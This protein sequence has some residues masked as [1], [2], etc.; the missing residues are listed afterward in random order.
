MNEFLDD[1]HPNIQNEMKKILSMQEKSISH[2]E[3]Y[4]KKA[5]KLSKFIS[6]KV[7]KGE[8]D[9]LMNRTDCFRIKKEINEKI[10]NKLGINERYGV[11]KWIVGLRRPDNFRGVRYAYIN[12]G[13]NDRPF[14]QVVKEQAPRS[15][16][17]VRNPQVNCENDLKQFKKNEYFQRSTSN[18]FSNYINNANKFDLLK[19]YYIFIH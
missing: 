18:I 17:I 4:T 5:E 8:S 11:N 12:M 13:S 1:F 16:E 7:K 14:W 19:V 15:V 10:D 3:D 6:K 2:S 9:L